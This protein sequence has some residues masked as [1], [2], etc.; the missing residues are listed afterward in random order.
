MTLNGSLNQR[1]LGLL[2]CSMASSSLL[3]CVGALKVY[4]IGFRVLL[5]MFPG[6]DL[7]FVE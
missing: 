3:F 7:G 6:G 2:L 4:W 5:I 1:L